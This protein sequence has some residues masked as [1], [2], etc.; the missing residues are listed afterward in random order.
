MALIKC[1]ECGKEV[2]DR[3]PA[4]IHCGFP[5]ENKTGSNANNCKACTT[6]GAIYFNPKTQAFL[7]NYCIECR[8]RHL[9]DDLVEIDYPLTTFAKDVDYDLASGKFVHFDSSKVN[10][11]K[12][13]L[14]EKYVSNWSSLNKDSESYR[15]NIENLYK[16]GSGEVHKAIY[17]RV[18]EQIKQNSK[19]NTM[20]GTA[21]CPR[22]G[23]SS[24]ATVNRGYSL[25]WGFLGSGKPVNVCQKCGHK[26]KP[27]T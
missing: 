19:I 5:L 2:S 3:A 17:D 21:C 10:E 14:F 8:E 9:K 6:C 24:I 27:G 22:C 15:L 25:F 7:D 1:P 11:K 18:T 20:G 23:S 16:N 26:F 13:Q 4:C 12:K